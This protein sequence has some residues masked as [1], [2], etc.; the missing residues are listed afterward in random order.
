MWE[1][2]SF[3]GDKVDT[4]CEYFYLFVTIDSIEAVLG[5]LHMEEIIEGEN[6]KMIEIKKA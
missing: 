6:A 1:L 2:W 5:V 3:F 4:V